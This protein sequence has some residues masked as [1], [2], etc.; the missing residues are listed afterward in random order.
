MNV[1][2]KFI[3]INRDNS[4][5]P[6]VSDRALTI[7]TAKKLCMLQRSEKG[8]CSAG[9]SFSVRS[10]GIASKKLCSGRYKLLISGQL[11]QKD[12]FSA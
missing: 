5:T 12:G 3:V 7:G 11:R 6:T 9:I 4:E 8:N 2:N 1:V 10:R